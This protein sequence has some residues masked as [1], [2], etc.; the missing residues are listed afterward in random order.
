VPT[1]KS[2]S[3][4]ERD[5]HTVVVLYE[6]NTQHI[7]FQSLAT[8]INGL[9]EAV[10]AASEYADMALPQG[11]SPLRAV[12]LGP[13]YLFSRAIAAVLP[14]TTG[15]GFRKVQFGVERRGEQAYGERRQMGEEETY[16]LRSKFASLSGAFPDALLIPGSV[17]WRKRIA[18]AHARVKYQDRIVDSQFV[19]MAMPGGQ[20]FGPDSTVFPASFE[21]T[22][23]R[24]VLTIR[25]KHKFLKRATYVAKNTAH[26]Y[27]NGNCIFKY[28]KIGDFHEVQD[29]DPR[30][31]VHLP[32][33]VAGRFVIPSLAWLHFGI[34]ICYDQSLSY[35]FDGPD[36]DLWQT[37]LQY[38]ADEVDFHVL[39]SASIQ[40]ML[41]NA[42]L[43]PGGHVLS[44]SSALSYNAVL[45]QQRGKLNPIHSI[46]K[47]GAKME[48][49][50]VSAPSGPGMYTLRV[51]GSSKDDSL[52]LDYSIRSRST[53]RTVSGKLGSLGIVEIQTFPVA[54]T[55]ISFP[56]HGSGW[57]S[58]KLGT[59]YMLPSG[60]YSYECN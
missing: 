14:K 42:N 44:C 55:E 56:G 43:K 29:V 18:D 17:A 49:F 6:V 36:G 33:G 27:F 4:E 13:E 40:P 38:T 59:H 19:N 41:Q 9:V 50:L 25:D 3:F 35:E 53:G 20:P 15:V 7:Q 23:G 37:S 21:S 16:S 2:S 58:V 32:A 31:T 54:D 10:Q 30:N 12:F 47:G 57:S 39:L 1:V 34:A 46:T 60:R 52:R 5:V 26:C 8:R 11:A 51:Y 24:P 48:F 28:N 45:H 22:P